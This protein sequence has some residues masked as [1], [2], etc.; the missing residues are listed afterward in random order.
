MRADTCFIDEDSGTGI[1]LL[2]VRGRI[3]PELG[4]AHS[5][6]PIIYL[7]VFIPLD[8]VVSYPLLAMTEVAPGS[9]S[10]EH[11]VALTALEIS[12]FG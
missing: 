2:Q 11:V 6:A 9:F 12:T 5:L 1:S 4:L 8:W 3:Q 10:R 7:S